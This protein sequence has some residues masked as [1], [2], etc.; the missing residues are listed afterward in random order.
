[1]RAR[2]GSSRSFRRLSACL[3]A[4]LLIQTWGTRALAYRPFT[5]TDAAVAE[6]SEI[7]LEAGPVGLRLQDRASVLVAPA[8]VANYGLVTGLEVVAEGQEEH[9]L[10]KLDGES[11]SSF[12]DG[13]LSLKGVL[14]RGVLQERHGPSVALEGGLLF[15]GSEHAWGAHLASVLSVS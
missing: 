7:E 14:R 6:A 3:G 15:P 11:R 13:A 1:M 10:G 8:L 12:E 2:R 9:R 5:G 4:W